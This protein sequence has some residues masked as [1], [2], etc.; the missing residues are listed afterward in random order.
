MK[1]LVENKNVNINDNLLRIIKGTL[2][3][4][5]IT[6]ILLLIFSLV[7]TYSNISDSM[8]SPVIIVITTIS[9]LAGS[10][11]SMI[12]LNKNGILNGG[13][14]G[15]IYMLFIYIMSSIINGSFAFS[16]NSIIFIL[17]GVVAGALGGI[18]GVNKK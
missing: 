16:M 5:I 4:I 1:S 8:I 3:S 7:L 6:L 9:I 15:I 11:I 12:G 13:V 2:L 17:C 14:I 18:I 10:S